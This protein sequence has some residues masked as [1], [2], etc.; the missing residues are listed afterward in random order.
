MQ[1]DAVLN[2]CNLY[3]DYNA[4]IPVRPDKIRAFFSCGNKLEYLLI[5]VFSAESGAGYEE[6]RGDIKRV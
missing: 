4:R 1:E 3:S 6:N 5:C 2:N